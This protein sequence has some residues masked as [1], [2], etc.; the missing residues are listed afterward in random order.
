MFP[1]LHALL[2]VRQKVCDPP[3]GGVRY[4]ELGELILEQ[5]R[6]VGVEC[7]AE[8]HKQGPGKGSWGVQ[9]LEGEV[10]GHVYCI[11]YRPDGSVGELQWVQEW[12]G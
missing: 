1:Q 6:E 7:R 9:M 10:Q 2:P 12:V 8:V 4:V 11:V 3:A 5:S